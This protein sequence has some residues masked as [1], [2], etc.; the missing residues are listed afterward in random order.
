MKNQPQLGSTPTAT[1]ITSSINLAVSSVGI[2]LT[3]SRGHISL[4]YRA[5]TVGDVNGSYTPNVNL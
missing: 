2:P 5:L 4:S 1:G 3:A